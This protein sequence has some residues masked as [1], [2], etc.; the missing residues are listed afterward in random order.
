MLALAAEL[1]AAKRD[2][3]EERHLVGK[4]LARCSGRTRRAR[5]PRSRCGLRPWRARD[6][7]RRTG[8]HTSRKESIKDTARVLGRMYDAIGYRGYDEY[9][10]E[11]AAWAGVPVINA[12]TEQWH[13]TQ[14]LADSMTIQE[15]VAK[16][17]GDVA[18][19][20]LGDARFNMANSYLVGGARLGMEVRIAAP[21]SIDTMSPGMQLLGRNLEEL[22]SRR[23]FALMII[24]FCSAATA[25][26]AFPSC[27]R[28]S[29]ALKTV[30]SRSTMPVPYCWSGQMLPTPATS[31]TTCIAS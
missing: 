4:T 30:S 18:F 8:S 28:P 10:D 24:I 31:S 2:G 15:H 9:L 3:R 17:L 19:C 14:V 21:A 13:P 20:Y 26:A 29:I 23:T 25:A 22:A 5:A 11:L 1:K 16:P 12:L 27:C 7:H 6:V